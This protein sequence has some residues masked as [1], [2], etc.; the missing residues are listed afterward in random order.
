MRW[1][2]SNRVGVAAE[3]AK[4]MATSRAS[5]QPLFANRQR[6]R[7]QILMAPGSAAHSDEGMKMGPR[8]W[9]DLVETGPPE[10]TLR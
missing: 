10:M 3:M 2:F 4:P 6:H 5:R 7:M 9:R 8:W 1:G